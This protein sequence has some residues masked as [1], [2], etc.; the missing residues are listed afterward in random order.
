MIPA[1]AIISCLLCLQRTR[2]SFKYFPKNALL[3]FCRNMRSVVHVPYAGWL[4][5]SCSALARTYDFKNFLSSIQV[6]CC[7]TFTALIWCLFALIWCLI[8]LLV[9]AVLYVMT[10]TPF[11]ISSPECDHLTPSTCKLLF[12]FLH[13]I[14]CCPCLYCIPHAIMKCRMMILISYFACLA[15]RFSP[16]EDCSIRPLAP[17]FAYLRIWNSLIRKNVG[18]LTRWFSSMRFH[19]DQKGCCLCCNPLS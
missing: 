17:L 16:R 19:F 10:F 14:L 15:A 7:N 8:V 11:F 2:G 12:M 1:I 6:C 4:I 18:S 5:L 9:C 13:L 3:S